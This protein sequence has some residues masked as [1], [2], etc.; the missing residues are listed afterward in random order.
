MVVE[1]NGG[2]VG[3]MVVWCVILVSVRW[4]FGVQVTIGDLVT[5]ICS[6]LELAIFIVA[7]R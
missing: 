7:C 4:W 1:L 2:H 6:E 5:Y 3:A